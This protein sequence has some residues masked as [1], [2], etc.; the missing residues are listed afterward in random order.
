MD[1][2]DPVHDRFLPRLVGVVHLP[3]L[4]GSA[5]GEAATAFPAILERARQDAIAWA[6]GGADAIIVEN[7]GDVPFARDRVEP[8]TIAAMTLA[9]AAVRAASGLPVGVNVLRNDVL[10][11]VSIAALAGGTFV[12]ANVYVGA[13]LTDQGHIEG[14]AHEVQALIRRLGAPLQ[15][16]ADIAVK[17]AAPI[18]S[19]PFIDEAEDAVVRGLAD[20]LIITGRG[21]GHPADL[22]D[23]RTVKAA[24]PRTPVYVGSGA[25]AT[26]IPALLAHADGVIVGTAAKRDGIVTNTVDLDRVKALFEAVSQMRRP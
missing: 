3:A 1:T 24:L 9:V 13:M 22:V 8:E 4:P 18:A 20:A 19:R 6:E 21:T 14:R 10:A 23:L 25:T 26:S 2:A 12:R 17:H 15:V 11:A 7:F 16:W 5:L